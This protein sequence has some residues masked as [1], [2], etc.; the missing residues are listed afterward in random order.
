MHLSMLCAV[1]PTPQTCLAPI[2][3]PLTTYLCILQ[4]FGAM[5]NFYIFGYLSHLQLHLAGSRCA[6]MSLQCALQ[7]T[8]YL[9][10]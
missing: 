8:V 6:S 4:G 7:C 3:V 1:N 9:N 10:Y 2:L 5:S